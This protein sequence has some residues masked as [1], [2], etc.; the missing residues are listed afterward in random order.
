[1]KE[2]QEG[3][4]GADA[5]VCLRQEVASRGFYKREECGPAAGA[6][7]TKPCRESR[8]DYYLTCTD[9]SSVTYT[10]PLQDETM[11]LKSKQAPMIK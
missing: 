1:M 7:S 2:D 10:H 3:R 11:L 5:K 4:H 8:L 9:C 6:D